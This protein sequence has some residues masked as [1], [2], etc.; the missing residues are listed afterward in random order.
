M[1]NN[2]NITDMD[3]LLSAYLD[4]EMS[5][6][7]R[8]DLE[9]LIAKDEGVAE[10]LQALAEAN[11]DFVEDVAL[12]D[13]MPMSETLQGVIDSLEKDQADEVE[14]NNVIQ[15]PFWKRSFNFLEQHR[16][17]A[18]VFVAGVAAILVQSGE[19]T[20]KFS[21]NGVSADGY[22]L[23][24]SHLGETLKMQLSGQKLDAEGKTYEAKFSF[25]SD[26]GQ[27]CRVV[28]VVSQQSE[29]RLVA[30]NEANDEWLVRVV[31]FEPVGKPN[32]ELEY[33]TASNQGAKAID[34]FL[35]SAMTQAP[36]SQEDE[37]KL[38]RTNWNLENERTAK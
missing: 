34:A 12:I 31:S 37:M 7:E 4:N 17:L 33:Q 35:D 14:T 8:Q 29:G 22:V 10:R 13:T 38:L 5:D 15:F 24:S 2:R 21:P 16:A 18:A 11:S 32:G 19:Q 6:S 26:D 27:I 30:C 36:L 28:D 9:V 25:V 3:E 20:S 1:S 23:A